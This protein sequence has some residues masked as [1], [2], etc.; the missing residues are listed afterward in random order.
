MNNLLSPR[1]AHFSEKI[2]LK[3]LYARSS[4]TVASERQ[5]LIGHKFAASSFTVAL[6]HHDL[7]FDLLAKWQYFDKHLHH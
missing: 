6:S 1:G 4:T 3:L 7:V 5:Q 2:A